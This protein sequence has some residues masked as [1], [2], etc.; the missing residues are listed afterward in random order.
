MDPTI[1]GFKT[2]EYFIIEG[3]E[4][5]AQVVFSQHSLNPGS[6]LALHKPG[7]VFVP[8][9]PTLRRQR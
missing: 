8:V 6:V 4:D 1:I 3:S 2:I 5:V 7:M 9:I